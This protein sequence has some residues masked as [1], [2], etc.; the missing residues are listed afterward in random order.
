MS[1][2]AKLAFVADGDYEAKG[3]LRVWS[4][5]LTDLSWLK[6]VHENGTLPGSMP[7]AMGGAP[8]LGAL[9][10]NARECHQ[11]IPAEV[12]ELAEAPS[13]LAAAVLEPVVVMDAGSFDRA[14]ALVNELAD[15]DSLL[16]LD[17]QLECDTAAM[18]HQRHALDDEVAAVRACPDDSRRELAAALSSHPSVDTKSLWGGFLLT[19]VYA[20]RTAQLKLLGVTS[21]VRFDE[22]DLP[23]FPAIATQKV[24]YDFPISAIVKALEAWNVADRKRRDWMTRL[25]PAGSAEWFSLREITK[26][27]ACADSTFAPLML[28]NFPSGETEV[29]AAT[30]A[31]W[32]YVD[33]LL[34]GRAPN[35]WNT[36]GQA[37]GLWPVLK[38]V[39]GSSANAGAGGD[40]YPLSFPALGLLAAM[41]LAEKAPEEA[42]GILGAVD[43]AA[44][45][46]GNAS[47]VPAV[48]SQSF[49]T[50]RATV[51]KAKNFWEKCLVLDRAVGPK[52]A[53]GCCVKAMEVGGDWVR[54]R[55]D[56]PRSP[57]VLKDNFVDGDFWR[58]AVFPFIRLAGTGD[59]GEAEL[60]A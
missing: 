50:A 59:R 53:G 22:N 14:R 48:P 16:W 26:E 10:R 33:Q 36:P 32:T 58:E 24:F 41:V 7:S 6:H 5:L 17:F 35:A 37:A 31:A 47:P 57:A 45:G 18:D 2:P 38:T 39:V 40:R 29:A 12:R 23:G 9:V 19:L 25:W 30:R 44:F 42:E 54:I 52:K 49:R 46:G 34:L 15:S 60:L 4:M 1:W 3:A 8:L 21:S 43:W 56:L 28:H 13:C 27:G 20:R 11:K 55:V 51:E